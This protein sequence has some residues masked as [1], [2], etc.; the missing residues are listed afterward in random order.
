MIHQTSYDIAGCGEK[1]VVNV[2]KSITSRMCDAVYQKK[3]GKTYKT[4]QYM[5]QNKNE[6]ES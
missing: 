2:A 5:A 6:K 4:D 3:T 1:Y